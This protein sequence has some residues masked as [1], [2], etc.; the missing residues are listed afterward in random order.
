MNRYEQYLRAKPKKMRSGMKMQVRDVSVWE[1][2][3]FDPIKHPRAPT[4]SF[5]L[6]DKYTT[7]QMYNITSLDGTP[8]GLCSSEAWVVIQ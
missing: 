8:G 5:R 1:S 7:N 3:I 6:V 4:C 2:F